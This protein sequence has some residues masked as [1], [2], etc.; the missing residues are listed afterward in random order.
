MSE[1]KSDAVDVLCETLCGALLVLHCEPK[2]SNTCLPLLIKCVESNVAVEMLPEFIAYFFWLHREHPQIVAEEH[3]AILKLLPSLFATHG[4]VALDAL[5][6]LLLCPIRLLSE[7]AAIEA[8][9]LLKLCAEREQLF[10][11]EL[12]LW[13]L[14]LCNKEREVP[15]DWTHRFAQLLLALNINAEEELVL[16]Q[17]FTDTI[18]SQKRSQLLF[19]STSF[20]YQQ[21]Q[22]QLETSIP[23]PR[24]LL[25]LGLMERRILEVLD[26][27]KACFLKSLSTRCS[28]SPVLDQS[29]FESSLYP[30]FTALCDFFTQHIAQFPLSFSCAYLASLFLSL[31]CRSVCGSETK[32]CS[33]W[34]SYV[35]PD[36]LYKR[37]PFNLCFLSLSFAIHTAT[38][39]ETL[40]DDASQSPALLRDNTSSHT[41]LKRF[42]DALLP[43]TPMGQHHTLL[44]SAVE[45]LSFYEQLL[46]VNLCICKHTALQLWDEVFCE[47]SYG[48]AGNANK[49]TTTL[50]SVR[51]S[52]VLYAV[53]VFPES[54]EAIF[55]PRCA[56]TTAK[57]PQQ[58]VFEDKLRAPPEV[59][60]TR[61]SPV[62]SVPETRSI[63]NDVKQHS[64]AVLPADSEHVTA[65]LKLLK[66]PS[67]NE[68]LTVNEQE[69]IGKPNVT[70]TL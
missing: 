70:E 61:E 64:V 52:W 56:T 47:K 23:Y 48:D 65:A 43:T 21:Q 57:P 60:P 46:F 27:L 29:A 11:N 10:Y 22:Q 63:G 45:A 37:L 41:A 36:V 40:C 28:T 18:P 69:A 30:T 34:F 16:I 49:A 50:E 66:E 8:K 31:H 24:F 38:A 55:P 6:R 1:L 67:T 15:E 25:V 14:L 13:A 4:D 58:T 2:K 44:T 68:M 42:S 39:A 17:L 32:C 35:Y 59:I 53:T 9:T 20:F 7:A 54:S 5:V 62:F 51:K 3:Q 33:I 26:L 19:A 12:V